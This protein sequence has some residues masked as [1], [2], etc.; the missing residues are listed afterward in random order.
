M[1][2]IL[3]VSLAV[4]LGFNAVPD[5]LAE[6]PL[7]ASMLLCGVPGTALVGVALNL[8]L[9]GRSRWSDQDEGLA[10]EEADEEAVAAGFAEEAAEAGSQALGDAELPAIP[11][12]RP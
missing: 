5:S 6:L 8:I 4:G 10:A 2:T 7:A 3:A 11:G 9:P 1:A 12:A